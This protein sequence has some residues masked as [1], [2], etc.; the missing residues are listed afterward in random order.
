MV[1]KWAKLK[2]A[3]RKSQVW[4]KLYTTVL[5]P[6]IEFRSMRPIFWPN[7]EARGVNSG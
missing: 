6:S 5:P 7:S 2:P 3:T 1:D 4:A